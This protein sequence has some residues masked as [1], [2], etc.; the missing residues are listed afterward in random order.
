M[1]TNSY[2]LLACPYLEYGHTSDCAVRVILSIAIHL[3]KERRRERS[4]VKREGEKEVVSREK[5]RKRWSQ[6]R[7]RERSGVK[8]D[9]MSER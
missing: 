4:G 6:E 3:Q 2:Y 1:I 5:E 9:K 8:R 7:R